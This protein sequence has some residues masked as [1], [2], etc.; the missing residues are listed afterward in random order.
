MPKY[1][2]VKQHLRQR[3]DGSPPGTPLPPERT[4]SEE[5]GAAR[6]TVRQALLELAVEGR[7][8]RMQGRGTFVAPPKETVPLRLRS[9][10][11]EWGSRGRSPGSKLV[12]MRTEPAEPEVAAQLGLDQDA[13]VHV[14][15]RLR[16]TDD[17]PTSLEIAYLDASRF[18]T[19]PELLSDGTSLYRLL[20]EHWGVEP[21]TAEQTIET[22]LASP[23]VARLLDAETGTPVLLLTRTTTDT[24]GTPFEFVRSVYRGDRF[25]FSAHLPRE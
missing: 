3:I 6:A 23:Q 14:V 11:E 22:V 12:E 4:L 19:L 20:N 25:R 18:A 8:V 24:S 5:F 2:T 1:Y 21:G 17:T 7:I 15:E 10:S 9:Y 13:V 16:L